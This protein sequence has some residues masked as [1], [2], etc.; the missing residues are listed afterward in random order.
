MDK[1]YDIRTIT[2]KCK[3]MSK[4][5]INSGAS[6]STSSS[7]SSSSACSTNMTSGKANKK[8]LRINEYDFSIVGY[9]PAYIC[10]LNVTSAAYKFGLRDNDY[11]IKINDVNCCRATLKSIRRLITKTS[12]SINDQ[13]YLV[14]TVQRRRVLSLVNEPKNEF[15][16]VNDE[17]D[18]ESLLETKT[19]S[20]AK[21][22][23]LST[24]FKSAMPRSCLTGLDTTVST[25]FYYQL[26]PTKAANEG[27]TNSNVLQQQQ[28][29]GSI[30]LVDTSIETVLDTTNSYSSYD[31]TISEKY[32][33]DERPKINHNR[34][35]LIGHLIDTEIEF[36]DFLSSGVSTFSRP[37]RG[38]FIRQNDYFILFQNIEKLLVISENVLQSLQKWS[39]HDIY[40]NI[41]LLYNN[42]VKLLN[43]ALNTYLM[44]YESSK[45]LLNDLL[46]NSKKFRSFLIVS[47]NYSQVCQLI[48]SYS[49]FLIFHRK[50]K[51][52]S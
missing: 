46:K 22:F 30:S 1:N 41:G 36:V 34:I 4:V 5:S 2:L 19:A 33:K 44:G 37:L 50:L 39:A 42:K 12:T 8:M 18:L 40:E 52:R 49:S 47:S 23:K 3:N 15:I 9:C 10:N 28:N 7:S 11:I 21:K 26:E 20:K 38:F 6:S 35:N 48:K 13:K 16:C 43:D 31:L 27:S 24:L 32:I 51:Q 29:I 25:E 45:L 17:E 14:L